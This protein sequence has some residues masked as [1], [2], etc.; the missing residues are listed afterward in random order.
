MNR[1]KA[2]RKN[3]NLTI[4]QLS[5]ALNIP[6]STLTN[7]ENGKRFPKDQNTWK[8]IAD[9]FNVSI[10]YLMG[11]DYS[12][13]Y[14]DMTDILANRIDNYFFEQSFLLLNK[15][16]ANT[17]K[18]KQGTSVQHYLLNILEEVSKIEFSNVDDLL[19]NEK[20]LQTAINQGLKRKT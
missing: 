18:L 2:L 5:E 8:K 13:K 10:A 7:Y 6:Q 15:F 3:R 16:Y 1:I 11:L 14:N 9:Y 19:E 12:E 17:E 4:T 20:E